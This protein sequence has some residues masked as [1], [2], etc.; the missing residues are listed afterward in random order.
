MFSYFF[1][2]IFSVFVAF[3]S[4]FSLRKKMKTFFLHKKKVF[5]FS[6]VKFFVSWIHFVV[7]D[8]SLVVVF[9]SLP[10]PAT[11]SGGTCR[12]FFSL[13]LLDESFDKK[14]FIFFHSCKFQF[15]RDNDDEV[16]SFFFLFSCRILTTKLIVKEL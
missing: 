5:H 16:A 11:D 10:M 12:L 7:D 14:W 6:S 15:I 4:F 8:V 13:F 3:N 2:H 9:F 1:L